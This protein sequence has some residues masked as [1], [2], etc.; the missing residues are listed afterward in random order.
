[1]PVGYGTSVAIGS[2]SVSVKSATN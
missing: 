1:V 2:S